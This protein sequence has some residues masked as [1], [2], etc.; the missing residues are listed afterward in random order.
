VRQC[1]GKDLVLVG[2]RESKTIQ[3]SVEPADVALIPNQGLGSPSMG[4]INH[5]HSFQHEESVKGAGRRKSRAQVGSDGTE[6]ADKWVAFKG[7]RE[8]E[9][10]GKIT[11]PGAERR[12]D[13]D[14]T[15]VIKIPTGRV[16][17]AVQREA[18]AREEALPDAAGAPGT[19]TAHAYR[20]S[21]E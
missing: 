14:A 2:V 17:S 11:V 9:A 3:E 20:R 5:T 13:A 18:G 19:T 10:A 16:V 15:Q 4:G 6:L 7:P 21:A 1:L 12:P 8:E